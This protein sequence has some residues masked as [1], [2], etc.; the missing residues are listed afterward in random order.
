MDK[1]GGGGRQQNSSGVQLMGNKWTCFCKRQNCGWN[2]THTSGFHKDWMKNKNDFTLPETHQF[3]IKSTT[4]QPPNDTSIPGKADSS[5][6]SISGTSGGLIGSAA[7]FAREN[8]EKTKIVLE[9]YK[10][11]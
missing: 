8:K 2:S 1:D 11:G 3:R 10:S 5:L 9:R 4:P 6:I 7:G